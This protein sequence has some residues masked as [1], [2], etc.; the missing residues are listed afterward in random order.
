MNAN[1]WQICD[2]ADLE[3]LSFILPPMFINSKMFQLPINPPYSQICC[4][5]LVIVCDL[6]K[7]IRQKLGFTILHFIPLNK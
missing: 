7:L 2:V 5:G 3:A 6:R 4:Y 1:V